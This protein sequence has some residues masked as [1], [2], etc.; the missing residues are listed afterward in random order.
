MPLIKYIGH[1]AFIWLLNVVIIKGIPFFLIGIPFYFS[2]FELADLLQISDGYIVIS[3]LQINAIPIN[4]VLILWILCKLFGQ[5]V[6]FP[7]LCIV[8]K[9]PPYDN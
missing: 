1:F 6:Y 2:L 9:H 7:Y 8:I 3:G 4:S 5:F